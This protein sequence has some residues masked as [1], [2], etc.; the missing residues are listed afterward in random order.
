MESSASIQKEYRDIPGWVSYDERQKLEI[1]N[2]LGIMDKNELAVFL[3]IAEYSDKYKTAYIPLQEFY[4]YLYEYGLRTNTNALKVEDNIVSLLRKVYYYLHKKNYCRS[5]VKDN[6][7][8]ALILFDPQT[9]KPEEVQALINKL[10]NEYIIIK[11][12]AEK[13]FITGDFIPKTGLSSKVLS[14]ISI[15]ELT[16]QKINE[17]SK[18]APLVKII[19]PS[20]NDIIVL[21]EDLPFLVELAFDKLRKHLTRNHDMAM[22]L[23]SKLKQQFQSLASVN[24]MDAIL[25]SNTVDPNLW[26]A[27][28]AEIMNMSLFNEKTSTIFESSEIIKYMSIIKSDEIQKKTHSDKSLEVLLKIMESYPLLFSKAQLLQLREKHAY[29]RLHSERDYIDLVNDLIKKYTVSESIDV[30]PRI[31]KVKEGE[32]QKFIYRSHILP[33]FFEKL[34]SIAYDLKKQ[35]NDRMDKEKEAILKDPLIRN[36]DL[37][38]NFVNDYFHKKDPVVVQVVEE[39][40][41]LYSLLKFYGK[42]YPKVLS[43]IDR[44]FYSPT[45]D[46]EVPHMK[47]LGDILL[48]SWDK[49]LRDVNNRIPFIYRIPILGFI[50]KLLSGFGK[51]MD[52]AV[53]NQLYEKKNQPKLSQLLAAKKDKPKNIEKKEAPDQGSIKEK[54]KIKMIKEQMLTLQQKLIGGKN[55]DDMLTYFE[56]KWNHTINP[57]ARQENINMVKTKIQHRLGFIKQVTADIVKRETNDM[58]KTESTF[59]KVADIE[60]LKNYISLFMIKY[61]LSK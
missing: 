2:D 46:D 48:I 9:L 11:K 56:S 27:L 20:N 34:D 54:Q 36:P 52:K 6:K 30:P 19:F 23:L 3:A 29:L 58:M 39:P 10:K 15:R 5:D 38:D 24:K 44:F 8:T 32:E 7:I 21:S 43:R 35:L 47:S 45:R 55:L 4:K 28:A 42:N 53:E 1:S 12:D 13:P 50:L 51:Y 31:V 25:K 17:L 60:S 26:A 22:L 41:L 16:Q 14:V 18:G 49:I 40:E 37:F 59:K 61:Y 33:N 57:E